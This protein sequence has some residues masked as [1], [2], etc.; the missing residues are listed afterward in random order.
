MHTISLT[1]STATGHRIPGHEGGSGKCARLHGHTYTFKV[2]CGSEVLGGNGFVIDF[3]VIKKMLDEWD[4]RL[5]LWDQDPVAFDDT[6]WPLYE[7]V[8]GV[9]RV[10]FVP[11][12]ENMADHLSARLLADNENLMFVEV[13]VHE[14]ASSFATATARLR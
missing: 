4:H 5:V 6:Y 2:T 14:S 13:E 7:E 12:A 11:T 9:I 8:L 10:P 1:H 3:S